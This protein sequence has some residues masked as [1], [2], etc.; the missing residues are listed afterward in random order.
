MS[1]KHCTPLF[2]P[3]FL[4]L[5]FPQRLGS[6]GCCAPL[7]LKLTAKTNL[8]SQPCARYA[9]HLEELSLFCMINLIRW[10]R[11]VQ[12]C[13]DMSRPSQIGFRA[14]FVYFL[15]SNLYVAYHRIAQEGT[16]IWEFQTDGAVRSS[17]ALS[18]NQRYNQVG[19]G[20]AEA[21]PLLEPLGVMGR[22][23]RITRAE[24][25]GSFWNV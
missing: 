5:L 24:C 25:F 16:K 23:G 7:F 15:M 4:G 11:H 9:V 8:A 21:L 22:Y 6:V 14:N 20:R 18:Q 12:T 2:T 13:P 19:H 1:E 10:S 3:S 17:A